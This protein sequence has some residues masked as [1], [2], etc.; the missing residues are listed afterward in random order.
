MSAIQ[1]VRNV[2]TL[3]RSDSLRVIERG[4]WLLKNEGSRSSP[5]CFCVSDAFACR[6]S[7]RRARLEGPSSEQ[8]GEG[9]K[10]GSHGGDSG[11]LPPA[12]VYLSGAVAPFRSQKK[13]RIVQKDLTFDPVLLPI[14]VGTSVEFVNEDSVAHSVFSYSAA[15]RFELG[16]CRPHDTE[17]A[18]QLFD[19]PG[20]VTL[21]CDEHERMRGFILVLDTPYF[22]ITDSE[23]K[24]RL[25]GLPKGQFI[26]KAW[27]NKKV[28]LERLVVLD[29]NSR[30][31]L[32]FEVPQSA[33]QSEWMKH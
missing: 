7:D 5:S 16:A 19:V 26:L 4:S 27:L 28:T 1:I 11:K 31:S 25:Q 29:E 17:A 30:V 23:G 14:Q 9:E 3:L 20:L 18:V 13:A 2:T 22:S 21:R 15:K 24:F 6:R 12:V 32:D 10:I 33:K 8:S